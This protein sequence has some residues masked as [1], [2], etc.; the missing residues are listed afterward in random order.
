MPMNEQQKAKMETWLC[1]IGFKGTC[2]SCGASSWAVGDL[3]AS[4]LID[5]HNVGI[6]HPSISM[7]QLICDKYS[8]AM[9]FAAAPIG[10]A[11]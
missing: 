5:D 1:P 3:I 10:L 6:G 7:A 11:K 4:Q 2:A 9:L 8:H